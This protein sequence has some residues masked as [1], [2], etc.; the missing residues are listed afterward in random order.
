[1]T[2]PKHIPIQDVPEKELA[3]PPDMPFDFENPAS[4]N[5]PRENWPEGKWPG[6]ENIPAKYKEIHENIEE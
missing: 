6:D 1:M 2:K 4:Q 5:H 3:V